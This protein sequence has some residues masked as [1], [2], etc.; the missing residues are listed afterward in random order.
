MAEVKIA[1]LFQ[2]GGSQAVRLPAEFRFEGDEVFISRDATTGAVILS[3]HAQPSTWADFIAFRD[4]FK[5]SD[6][7][8]DE[9]D[10]VMNDIID[11]RARDTGAERD[12][13]L[14]KLFGE[15]ED[16]E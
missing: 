16:R 2:N 11:E 8:R 12:A 4:S 9:F 5:I 1:K 10:R 7:E 13:Y 14:D 15:N 6:E 3:D